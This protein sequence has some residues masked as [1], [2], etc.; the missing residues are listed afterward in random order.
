MNCSR[1][2]I[3]AVREKRQERREK[4]ISVFIYLLR[5]KNINIIH[6]KYR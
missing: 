1:D 4:P 5:F 6:M 3:N 2:S